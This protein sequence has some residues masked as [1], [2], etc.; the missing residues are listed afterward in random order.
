MEGMCELLHTGDVFWPSSGEPVREGPV[1][2]I[3]L[4]PAESRANF[5]LE[6]RGDI[7]LGRRRFVTE[8]VSVYKSTRPNSP[9]VASRSRNYPAPEN[10]GDE[11]DGCFKVR[12]GNQ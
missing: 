8:R 7:A 3:L 9:S 11:C 4:P 2:R 10:R 6:L 1:V 5:I 12:L